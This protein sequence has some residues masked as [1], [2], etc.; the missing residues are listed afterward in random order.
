MLSKSAA[1]KAD[2]RI[3]KKLPALEKNLTTGARIGD[4]SCAT[5]AMNVSMPRTLLSLTSVLSEKFD[6]KL[7]NEDV[8]KE[9]VELTPNFALSNLEE[10]V[11]K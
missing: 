3:L 1:R 5:G 2:V 10:R 7:F 11:L 4:T 8:I 6:G 9:R